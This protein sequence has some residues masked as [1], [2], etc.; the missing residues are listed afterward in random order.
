MVKGF[1]KI[2]D[3]YYLFNTG[4]GKMY[5]DAD[6]WVTGNNAYGFVGGMYHFGDDGVM[7]INGFVRAGNDTYYYANGE[8]VKGFT[9]IG[10]DYYFFN[11]S[12]GKMY[13]DAT[14]WVAGENEYGI[15]GGMH[16]FDAEGKMFVPDTVNGKREIVAENGNLYF[17]I[18]GARMY[19]GLYEL[20][21]EYYFAEYSG[22]L[23]VEKPV[24]VNTELL[25]GNGWYYFGTDGKFVK[26]GFVTG[27]GKTFYY[28]D[29]V[30]AKGLTKIGEDYYFFNT[31]SGMMYKDAKMW[32]AGNNDYGF[33]G[34]M[35]YFGT[36]G[37]M[38]NS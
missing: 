11:K 24:Y 7:Q 32:V 5:K 8:L 25:S 6:M 2:G 22:K 31:G 21:G 34:G 35:Y 20:D 17:T 15:A 19:N 27:G 33:V 1:T 26:T 13:K 4:S 38:T 30:R 10:N 14:M 9:K 18:D 12:S 28:A 3:D 16:Y 29:G 36:D 23:A 37:K